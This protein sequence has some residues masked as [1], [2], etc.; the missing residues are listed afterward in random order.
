VGGNIPRIEVSS[1][2]KLD[3]EILKLEQMIKLERLTLTERGFAEARAA[4]P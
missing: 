3:M 2:Q 1:G 4:R